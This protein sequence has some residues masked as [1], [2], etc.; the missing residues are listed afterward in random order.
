M[1]ANTYLLELHHIFDG[2]ASKIDGKPAW[3]LSDML[4]HR[5]LN[6]FVSDW[7]FAHVELRGTGDKDA[8]QDWKDHYEG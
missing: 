7:S 6:K 8:Y 2:W 4:H 1:V 3:R 5:K